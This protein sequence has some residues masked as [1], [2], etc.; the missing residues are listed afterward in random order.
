MMAESPLIKA[1]KACSLNDAFVALLE[2]EGPLLAREWR[3]KESRSSGAQTLLMQALKSS[4]RDAPA[5]ARLLFAHS[6]IHAVDKAGNTHLMIASG[7]LASD[8]FDLLIADSDPAALNALGDTAL[9]I[10]AR[11]HRA[12]NV[13][14][15]LPLSD[16]RAANSVGDTALMMAAHLP[17]MGYD[18][19]SQM[20]QIVNML[21]PVSDSRAKNQAGQDAFDIAAGRHNFFLIELLSAQASDAQLE[22]VV[23]SMRD[24]PPD[25]LLAELPITF[26]HFEARQLQKTIAEAGHHS[27]RPSAPRSPRA[28]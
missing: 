2:R 5:L 7:S 27:P 17:G 22:A 20:R 26:A 4:H 28:L 14:K 25:A 16:P 21:L 6:D 1:V 24:Y 19:Q 15:L 18:L 23:Q 12:A 9:M 3:S 13:A 11:N 8:N 10:A